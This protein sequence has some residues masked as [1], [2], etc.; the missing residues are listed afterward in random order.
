MQLEDLWNTR[1]ILSQNTSLP[2][3]EPKSNRVNKKRNY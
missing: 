1:K 3:W 2:E